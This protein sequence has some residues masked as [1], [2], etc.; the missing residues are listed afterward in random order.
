[1]KTSCSF[2]PLPFDIAPIC[3]SLRQ[4]HLLTIATVLSSSLAI[5]LCASAQSGSGTAPPQD[6]VAVSAVKLAITSMGGT[7][8]FGSIQD[9]TV[10]AQTTTPSS[11]NSASTGQITWMTI[12]M[13]I[14][15][16][17]TAQPGSSIFTVQNGAGSVEDASGNV[18]PMD[19]RLAL[20]LYPYHLPGAVLLNLLNAANESLSVVQ[21]TG[22][23]PNIV[24]VRSL[25]QMSDPTLTPVTQQDWYIDTSTGLPSRV[26]YYLPNSTNPSQDGTTTI[27]FTSWQ[28]TP[29]IMMPQTM[30]TQTNGTAVSSITIGTPQF[31]QGLTTSIFQLP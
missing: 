1:V 5:G 12:G 3:N 29:T 30:Q 13:S 27:L 14:R 26:D 20:T 16:A 6:P 22:S 11:S 21:D 2:L 28:K 7:A 23:T 10:T 19:S 15:C 25:I 18:S 17:T 31:N 24:H 4:I 8:S 9:V